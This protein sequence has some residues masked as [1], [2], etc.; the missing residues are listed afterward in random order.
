M[1]CARLVA[2]FNE[3]GRRASPAEVSLEQKKVFLGR[4]SLTMSEM[5]NDMKQVAIESWKSDAISRRHAGFKFSERRRAW[6]VRDLRSTN[7]VVSFFCRDREV[8]C[9]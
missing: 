1:S 8:C 7:G 2:I 6:Y 5:D 3:H 9:T 4:S